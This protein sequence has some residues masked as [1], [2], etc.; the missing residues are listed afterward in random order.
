MIV[1]NAVNSSCLHSPACGHE[2]GVVS[3]RIH[4]YYRNMMNTTS[5]NGDTRH[6]DA[7]DNGMAIGISVIPAARQERQVPVSFSKMTCEQVRYPYDLIY[8]AGGCQL[9]AG[10]IGM[11]T[12]EG[13]CLQIWRH[14]DKLQ[15]AWVTVGF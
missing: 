12:V 15:E 10:R 2:V 7:G 5:R 11:S 3:E 13:D 9:S 1:R 14:A 6:Q 4:A 8:A